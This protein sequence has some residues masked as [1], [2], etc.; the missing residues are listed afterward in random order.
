MAAVDSGRS[1]K[2]SLRKTENQSYSSWAITFCV[3][4]QLLIV[5]FTFRILIANTI[6]FDWFQ[7]CEKSDEKENA[8]YNEIFEWPVQ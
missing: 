6:W 4:G 5:L 8:K 2:C 1:S 7:K 3:K